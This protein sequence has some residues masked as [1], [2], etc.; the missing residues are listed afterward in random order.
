MKIGI[1][2]DVPLA[3]EALRR[4]LA[5]RPDFEIA[6]IAHDGQQAIDYCAA[7]TPD[8][9]LMD[10]VMPKVDGVQASRTIMA[11][12]P[13]AI[14]VVTVDVGANAWR[15]YE[16]MG[17]GAL[18]AVDTP[19]LA[20][21]DAR[22]GA[23]ALIG[24]IDQIGARLAS[25]SVAIASK[26]SER[27]VA[28]G[29]SAGGPSALATLL[30]ALPKHFAAAIVIVQHVD[31]AFAE[32]MAQWL[33]AQSALPVRIAREGDRPAP[34]VV[35]LAATNDHLHFASAGRLGY[36]A[37]PEQLPY[38]PSVDVFFQSV[39]ERWT[40]RALGVLLTGM[41]RDGAIGLKSMRAKGYHTIAQDEATSAVYGMP[42]AAA[43]LDAAVSILP[44][45][46]IAGAIATAFD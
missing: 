11:R 16:A 19:A 10:L 12:S 15:V 43:A 21:S 8:V 42:K 7:H 17:A 38:R 45:P 33:D 29:A 32:G 44:L 24:K 25:S 35:L 40:G 37:H 28:I 1:V 27:L 26:S 2:N 30:G 4:A 36:T 9:V 20:G 5:S 39:T 23:A 3:V 13:C 46:R 34:G 31:R 41:G 6:W 14:L 18:D 22:R